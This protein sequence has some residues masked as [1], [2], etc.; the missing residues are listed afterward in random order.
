ML[1]AGR[2]EQKI[3]R[4]ERV[5]VRPVLKYAMTANDDV[6]FILRMGVLQVVALRHIKFERHTAVPEEFDEGF[7]FV[8]LKCPLGLFAIYQRTPGTFGKYA[9][10]YRL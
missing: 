9:A 3:A 5:F 2:Y 1:H 4:S 10:V 6:N 8:R 7:T